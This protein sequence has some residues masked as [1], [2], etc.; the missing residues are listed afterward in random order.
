MGREHKDSELEQFDD[1]NVF[2]KVF[3]SCVCHKTTIF[4]WIC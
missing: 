1:G 3:A 4:L 2:A